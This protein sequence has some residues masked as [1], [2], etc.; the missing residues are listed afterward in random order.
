MSNKLSAE[1]SLNSLDAINHFRI[2]NPGSKKKKVVVIKNRK[3]IFNDEI[4]VIAGDYNTHFQVDIIWEDANFDYKGNG[5]Y[6]YY[7]STYN[8]ITYES[9][10][11]NIY[12]DDIVIS[13]S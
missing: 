1:E 7:S 13:I 4:E 10:V 6:G 2:E 9:S 12:S 5:L 11:L 8:I 3:I